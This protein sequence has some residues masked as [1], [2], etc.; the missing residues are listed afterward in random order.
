MNTKQKGIIF[1]MIA[2]IL[3]G[4]TPAVGKLTYAMGNNGV[5][6]AFLRHLFVLPLFLMIV[7]YQGQSLRLNKSQCL[8]VFKV[9]FFGN[10]LTIVMLYSSYEYIG[11]GS[12]TVLHFLYP[13]FVV[14]MNFI[15]YHQKLNKQQLCCLAL[16]IIGI[17]C[18]MD[19]S[20]SSL[21]GAL[22]AILSG[23]FFAYYMVGMDHSSIRYMSPYVFNFYLVLMNSIV[24]LILAFLLGRVSILP[25]QAYIL[26]G[27]VAVLTS[28]IGV[29]LLQKGIYCL[30]ASLTAIL[31]TLEPITSIVVGV[32]WL[33]E[34]LTLL[35]I[36][37]CILVLL[38][39]FI[40]VKAQNQKENI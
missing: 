11:V 29:V 32:V 6:L 38:S 8:D 18:F 26:S 33:N 39:T 14:C 20:S 31:S 37:G 15:L 1:T 19:P 3:F 7:I 13:L 16:A 9:G 12:A 17:F 27:V 40:L 35:K 2:T 36:I 24:I 4:V 25:L 10:T 21:M 28:L 34:S 30:G 23:V 22:L 5:Q